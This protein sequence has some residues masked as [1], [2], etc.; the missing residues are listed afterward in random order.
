MARWPMLAALAKLGR[1]RAAATTLSRAL[2]HAAATD[3]LDEG[4]VRALDAARRF[5]AA[6]RVAGGLASLRRPNATGP[7]VFP[8]LQPGD[9]PSLG[10]S[11]FAPLVTY[12]NRPEVKAGGAVEDFAFIPAYHAGPLTDSQPACPVWS[13]HRDELLAGRPA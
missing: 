7:G 8:Q 9:L 3:S 5:G 13:Q 1:P 4:L 2:T 10:A 6:A 12:L 11:R